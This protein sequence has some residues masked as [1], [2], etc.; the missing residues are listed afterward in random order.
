MSLAVFVG[1]VAFAVYVASLRTIVSVDAST[2]VLLSYS[3]VRDGDAFLDEFAPTYEQLSY[4]SSRIG[5]HD[6]AR[7]PP[8]AAMLAS[9][10]VALGALLGIHPP[11]TASVTVVGKLA[12]AAI[13]AASVVFVHLAAARL[14]GRAA[15]TLAAV[16][17][18]FGTATWPISGGA[19]WVHGT[20]Q[21]F[22]A[23][24]LFLI[25]SPRPLSR[26]R[27]G[28]AFALATTARPTTALFGLA[29]LVH[30]L[31]KDLPRA[32]PYVAWAIPALVILLLYDL[33]TTGS[34]VSPYTA[35][36]AIAV[37]AGSGAAGLIVGVAGNLFSPS[38]GLFVFSPFLLL[39][40][41][42]LVRRARRADR[43]GSTLRWQLVAAAAILL[44][45]STYAEWWAGFS[46]GN[47][48]L[49]ETLPLLSLGVALWLRRH[50][51]WA[52][53]PLVIALGAPAVVFALL[54]A[55]F[56]DWIGWSWEATGGLGLGELV[57]RMD[58]AQPWHTLVR[59][60]ERW[61]PLALLPLAI[62]AIGSRLIFA[63]SVA[64]PQRGGIPR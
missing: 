48:Y 9:P 13:A 47:R 46:Y 62:L 51:G 32:A 54:G 18:A 1:L 7:Y 36:G 6:V 8:G 34:P 16:L 11:A 20:A 43:V 53:R 56:Y 63:S 57:W 22:V 38:R 25:L 42:E 12:A 30:L 24:G 26:G 50:R 15:A 52:G 59:V 14:A 33:A 19:L 4:W 17:Y 41:Y 44:V 21:L 10:V 27:A 29:G 3:F 23:A 45:Y 28:L 58:L 64:T 61:E 49:A 2:N 55:L 5:D 40:A 39:G 35:A 31:R 60:P 37:G